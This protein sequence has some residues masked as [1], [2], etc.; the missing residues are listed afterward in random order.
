MTRPWG[1][2]DG[3]RAHP[4]GLP[5]YVSGKLDPGEVA[6]VEE[7]L[8]RCPECREEVEALASMRETLLAYRD[9]LELLER[10]GGPEAAPAVSGAGEIPSRRAPWAWALIGAASAAL[11]LLAAVPALRQLGGGPSGGPIL[12]EAQPIVFLPL[13]R[14]VTEGPVLTGSGPWSIQVALPLGWPDAEYRLWIEREDGGAVRGSE[15]RARP[16]AGGRLTVL[17]KSLP[18]PGRYRMRIEPELDDPGGGAGSAYPFEV[19]P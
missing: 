17:L 11:L 9:D 6:Q 16:A 10:V 12:L 4:E 14:G 7:H 5:W 19:S 3:S 13:Q 2:G 8:L 15:A 1:R 18:G